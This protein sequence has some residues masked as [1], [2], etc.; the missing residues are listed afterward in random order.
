MIKLC[1][2]SYWTCW[3]STM[4][5]SHHHQIQIKLK[6]LGT[7]WHKIYMWVVLAGFMWVLAGF[8]CTHTYGHPSPSIYA[9]PRHPIRKGRHDMPCPKHRCSIVL[10]P[11]PIPPWRRTPAIRHVGN[12][13]HVTNIKQVL[14]RRSPLGA[15]NSK[16]H[17]L[18]RS[19]QVCCSVTVS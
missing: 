8:S 9:L 13:L 3:V 15:P 5:E 18:V 11:T 17:I 19:L 7:K 2:S 1:A 16:R 12:N 4:L 10:W 14:T 6:W